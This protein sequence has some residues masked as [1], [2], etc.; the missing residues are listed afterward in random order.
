M[1]FE[2]KLQFFTAE[3]TEPDLDLEPIWWP[4]RSILRQFPFT[5]IAN[6]GDFFQQ[7]ELSLQE[8]IDLHLDHLKQV[9]TGTF[10]LSSWQAQIKPKLAV[11]EKV[12]EGELKFERILMVIREWESGY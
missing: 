8:L 10:S 5:Q 3:A 9:K 4:V 1:A 11:I 12:I 7:Y 6:T 2:L